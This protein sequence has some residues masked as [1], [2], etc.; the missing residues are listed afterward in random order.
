MG[1]RKLMNIISIKIIARDLSLGTLEPY[2]S[3]S[4]AFTLAYLNSNFLYRVNTYYADLRA[5]FWAQK[6]TSAEC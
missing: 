6:D 4:A 2:P 3:V 5:E 1:R